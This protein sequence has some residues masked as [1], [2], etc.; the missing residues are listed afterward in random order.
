M[1]YEEFLKILMSYK[2]IDE[3]ISELY[4]IG[5]DFLEGKYRVSDSVSIMFNAVL[6][7]HYTD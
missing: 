1:S 4:D 7:S 3:D 6:D 2:K 5:F